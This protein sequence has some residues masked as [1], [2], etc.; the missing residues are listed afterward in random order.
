MKFAEHYSFL[1]FNNSFQKASYI[2]KYYT[3]AVKPDMK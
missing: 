1:F 2:E 3:P